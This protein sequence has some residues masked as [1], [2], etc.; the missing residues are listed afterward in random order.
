MNLIKGFEDEIDSEIINELFKSTWEIR[1][2]RK[3]DSV[4]GAVKVIVP[5]Y[6]HPPEMGEKSFLSNFGL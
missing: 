5:V 3:E 2:H 6:F 4:E 1:F